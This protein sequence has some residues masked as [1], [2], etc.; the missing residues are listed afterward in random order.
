VH[1][2]RAITAA[3]KPYDRPSKQSVAVRI[4]EG[5]DC[6]YFK[7]AGQRPDFSFASG[8]VD[9]HDIQRDDTLGT[10]A[11]LLDSASDLTSLDGIQEH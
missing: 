7:S 9:C 1:V 5:W 3:R 10:Q 8:W 6:Y 2:S 11:D 4:L